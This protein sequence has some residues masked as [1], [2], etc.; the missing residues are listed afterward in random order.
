MESICQSACEVREMGYTPIFQNSLRL[1]QHDNLFYEDVTLG[2]VVTVRALLDSWSMACTLSTKVIPQLLHR[3]VLR[4]PTLEPTTTVLIGCGGSRTLP[5]GMCDLEMGL[6]DCKVIVPTLIVENQSEELIFGSNLLRYIIDRFKL[7]QDLHGQSPTALCDGSD[8]E[9]KLLGLLARVEAADEK[10]QK[11]VGTVKIKRAVTLE[12]MTEHLIWGKL[13]QVNDQLAGFTVV[14]EPTTA[15]SKS[16]TVLVGRSVSILRADGWLPLKVINPSDKPVTLRRNVKLADVCTCDSLEMFAG[17]QLHIHQ[18]LQVPLDNSTRH[19][20]VSEDST[21]P[22]HPHLVTPCTVDTPQARLRGL[23]LSDVDIEECD[24][25]PEYKA[26]LAELIVQ[27][28]S[29]FSRDKLDC[30]KATGFLHR[31]RVMDEKPFRLPCRRIPPTQY[32]K[33][34]EALDEMEEREIIRKSSSEFASPLV[35]VWKKSGDLRI[36]NDFRWINA[37]TVKD[38][39]PL[40]HPAD[41]LAALGG[42]AFF[43]TMDLTSGYYNVEVHEADRKYTAFTSPFGLYEYNRIPQGLCNSPATFMRMMLNIFGD[44]NFMSLLCYL[45]DVLVFAPTEDLA[46]ERLHMVFQRLQN[47]N[48]KLAPKKCHFLRKSVKFLC[49]IISIDGIQSDPDKVTAITNIDESDLMEIGTNIPSQR[50]IRSFLG[51]VVYYQQ[52]IEGCSAMA[53]PLFRLISPPKGP[54]GGGRKRRQIH[55]KL[56]AEDWTADCQQ[57]FHQLRQA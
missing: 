18:Q 6:Y 32:E 3:D 17:S 25:A 43:S 12:P 20:L 10:V 29:I 23:G 52:F 7:R 49:H 33:L 38:A 5:S 26:K 22:D 9:Q 42:N 51:M 41:A 1:K 11:A 16:R 27:Y 44:K 48:L 19:S 28:Q 8:A 46:L 53:K 21:L 4:S 47:H 14:V 56:H 2:G 55:K 45:D 34:R 13:P 39:H 57:A 50:K 40:P 37:H 30:G 54:R 24:V 35:I 15:R 31:I 36:C